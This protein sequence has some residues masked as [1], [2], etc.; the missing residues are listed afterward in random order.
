M[1]KKISF[2]Q[3]GKY[4][5]LG[6]QLF[7]IHSIMGLAERLGAQAVF[8]EWEYERFF[9]TP[10]P[11]GEMVAEF[12]VKER[13]FKH[14]E[15]EIP[16]DADLLGY[17]QS[18][19]YFGSFR[20]RFADALLEKMQTKYAS[21]FEKQTICIQVRRGDYVG[22]PN[23]YQLPITF[24]F[25]ALLAHFP[26][27]REFNLLVI[28]D[29]I[30]YCKVHFGSLPDVTY[31]EGNLDIEDMAL[32]SLCNHFIISNSSF[33]WFTAWF[34][35]KEYSKVIH[36]G[37]MFAGALQRKH[38]SESYRPA[39]WINH[40][41]PDYKLDLRDT[42]FTIP[43]FYDHPTRKENFDL[44]LYLLLSELNTH[45]IVGEQGGRTF[46]GAGQWVEYMNFDLPHFHRTK[47]LNDMAKEARTRF[48]VNWDCD[49]M[50]PPIQLYMAVEELRKGA[51]MVFPYG[52]PFARMPR[53]PY[54]EMLNGA[55]D[56]GVVRGEA[57]KG[58]EADHFSV[59][60]AVMFD[61]D[62]FVDGG[63]ENEKMISF[64]PEDVER[65]ERFSRLGY[66]IRRVNGCLFHLN[67]FVGDNSSPR[68]PLFAA[69]QA[70]LEYIRSLSDAELRGY[71]ERWEWRGNIYSTVYYEDISAGAIR[72]ARLVM[73]ELREA[74][75]CPSSVVD[76]GCGVGEWNNGHED[77]IGVDY[78]VKMDD[79]I[80]PRSRFIEAN[81]NR[82]FPK[83]ERRFDLA[84]CLEVAEHLKP[85][86]AAP[87]VEYLCSLSDTVLFSA[88]IPH[89]GGNGHINEQWQGYWMDLFKARGYTGVM[90]PAIRGNSEIELWYRQNA[91]LF[92]KGGT[93]GIGE[94]ARDFVLPEYYLEIV[95]GMQG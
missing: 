11:H 52:G 29:D 64:G 36:S 56:I 91:I 7:Q 92:V 86:R 23:Y 85:T 19:Q 87:L 4:G 15:W 82:E 80:I 2:S 69:N 54:Y 67:H 83:F 89:Q 28:S 60:G 55:R 3:L 33:G 35:E 51:D 30:E 25:D 9:S 53:N 77:Y 24:Y 20:L 1:V 47:M 38:S 44:C 27:W 76:I 58:R 78:R 18:E 95:K 17:M 34:G 46:E 72:S 5:R 8:P 70:E 39:R 68:N 65:Y 14:H 43:V 45:I 12:Q 84:L 13:E 10:L 22:N 50:I 16:Q 31:A 90:L 21:L 93:G 75:I 49:V 57:F 41:K 37:Y 48:V 40:H 71:V 88:A 74:G 73:Q 63:M 61:K 6:N 42:T 81:L 62:S 94:P 59:G 26:N 32:G 66:D 79:L